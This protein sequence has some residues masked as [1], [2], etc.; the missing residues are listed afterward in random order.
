MLYALL[1]GA[2]KAALPKSSTVFR[3]GRRKEYV[4]FM[5][6]LGFCSHVDICICIAYTCLRFG[7]TLAVRG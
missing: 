4:A 1:S 6:K 3:E 5:P 7:I 2:L